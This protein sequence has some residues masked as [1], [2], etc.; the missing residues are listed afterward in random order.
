MNKPCGIE[1]GSMVDNHTADGEQSVLQPT[2]ATSL[3]LVHSELRIT[4]AAALT[5][6]LKRVPNSMR[7]TPAGRTWETQMATPHMVMA[8]LDN[9]AP[10][11]LLMDVLRESEC[12]I[13]QR[14][15]VA[16][17]N[18]Y[19]DTMAPL[20]AKARSEAQGGKA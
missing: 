5:G 1:V 7:T 20:I 15:R 11:S 13:V 18:Q 9:E 14:L 17:I 16:I 2:V 8:T 6:A 4:M 12:P 10:C 3:T 19:A